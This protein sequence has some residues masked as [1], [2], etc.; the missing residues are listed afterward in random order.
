MTQ[1]EAGLYELVDVIAADGMRARSYQWIGP[2]D[3]LTRI[4]EWE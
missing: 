4:D 1:I 3:G 2:T